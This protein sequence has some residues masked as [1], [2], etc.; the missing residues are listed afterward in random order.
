MPTDPRTCPTCG[1]DDHKRRFSLM[2]RD[3]K[4]RAYQVGDHVPR[5]GD[6]DC[7]DL[8]HDAAPPAPRTPHETRPV[9]VW[10]DVDLGIADLV[11]YLNTIPGVRTDASCQGTIG[12]GGPAPYKAQ[13]MCTWT[14]EA[15]K[16]LE[17]EFDISYPDDCNKTWGYVHP[18]EG[19]AAP[20]A[21]PVAS[22]EICTGFEIKVNTHTTDALERLQSPEFVRMLL[23]EK[24]DRLGINE[25]V[26]YTLE[27]R[28]C[29]GERT[30]SDTPPAPRS[31]TPHE[32]QVCTCADC[33]APEGEVDT[34]LT[35]A[36]W[37]LIYPE[38]GGILCASCIV[39]RAEKLP[40]VICV[41]A[42][43]MFA[44]DFED[45]APPAPHVS[46]TGNP[47]PTGS[48]VRC[49]NQTYAGL[50]HQCITTAIQAPNGTFNSPQI[51]PV[52]T[53]PA[54]PE[55]LAANEIIEEFFMNHAEQKFNTNEGR[56]EFIAAIIRKRCTSVAAEGSQRNDKMNAKE[57]Y[58]ANKTNVVNVPRVGHPEDKSGWD[59]V[60]SASEAKFIAPDVL[61]MP[62]WDVFDF[63][64]SYRVAAEGSQPSGP[65][66]D[67]K[68][69]CGQA[70]ENV[71]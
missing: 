5:V 40:H 51:S 25:E 21:Q 27:V 61:V 18:R 15:F 16:R 2:I 20:P 10:V 60:R 50:T 3:R 36:Q 64:E 30:P 13:V 9:Q 33:G 8:W 12:E 37:L 46:T 71:I 48:C 55:L 23:G 67:Y 58:E 6:F 26:D 4:G 54:P 62:L 56:C 69:L 42:R 59:G 39:K 44:S 24:F 45:A 47:T 63:A 34:V 57:F 43:I 14:E 66:P 32:T 52:A 49:G 7:P 22:D 41:N 1:S 19:W 17:R 70:E 65:T 11:I 29:Y 31:Q 68:A 35:R 38:E 53:L 28:R